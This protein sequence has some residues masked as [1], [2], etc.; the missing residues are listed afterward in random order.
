[1]PP[2]AEMGLMGGT[3]VLTIGVSKDLELE[4]GAL[5]TVTLES[6]TYAYVGSALGPGGYAR[7]DRHREVA[8][9]DRETRHWH[10]D[11]LL[12]AENTSIETV[13]RLPDRALECRLAA[14][15]GDVAV[16]GFGAS[17]CDCAGHL[18]GPVGP[19][20]VTAACSRLAG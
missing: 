20:A 8:S 13:H 5:G 15:I 11:Y 19:G 9:G 17:D 12:R 16:A 2:T 10:L 6:G 7:I 3:Y 4:V 14:E 1:M 18:R